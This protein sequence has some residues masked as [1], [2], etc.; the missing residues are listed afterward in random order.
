MEIPYVH[1]LLAIIFVAKRKKIL[2]GS[3]VNPNVGGLF[4]GL[5]CGRGKI[6]AYL[7]LVRIMLET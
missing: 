5:F 1:H 3:S 6:T 2:F 7:R 4:R